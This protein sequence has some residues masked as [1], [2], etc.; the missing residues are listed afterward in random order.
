MRLEDGSDPETDTSRELGPPEFTH[1]FLHGLRLLLVTGGLTLVMFLGMM[2]ISIIATAIPQ[3][4][5]DFHRLEHVGWYIGVYSLCSAALQPLSGKVFTYFSTKWS[6]LSF[7]FIFEVGSCISGAAVS[8]EMLI[9]GRAIAG[10]GYSGVTNGAL[11]IIASAIAPPKRPCMFFPRDGCANRTLTVSQIG[12]ILGPILGGVFTEFVS[13]RWCFYINLP[14]GAFTAVCLVFI[15]IPDQVRK[16]PVSFELVRRLLPRFDLVGFALFAPAAVMGLLALQFGAS[17]YGWS[18]PV[19]I[20]LFCG[21]AGAAALFVAWEHRMKDDA[22]MPFDVIRRTAV[23]SCSINFSGIMSLAVV[24]GNYMPIY[25]Q[26]VRGLSPAMSGV[27]MLVSTASN[28]LF[29]LISGALMTRFRYPM[30]W[31]MASGALGAVACGL[32]STWAPGST[33][34]AVFG[35][36]VLNGARGLGMQQP[37]LVVQHVLP[38]G[39]IA[40][41]NSLMVFFSNSA[42]AVMVTIGN[43]IFQ[44]SLVAEL[45][46]R[47]PSVSPAAAIAAGGSAEAVRALAIASGADVESLLLAY[48]LSVNRVFYLLAGICVVVFV[49][50]FGIGWVDLGHKDKKDEEKV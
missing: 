29:I 48:S 18:S 40:V 36:Q 7:F 27:Y 49:S 19:V 33:L 23:W 1:E 37:I 39:K 47:A 41:G 25:F 20:G 50:A 12:M 35:Y 2:D 10:L 26:S 21:C 34:A 5:S 45:A 43:V 17:T 32:M 13:W 15:D 8:S 28:I 14:L 31:S 4:T 11:T 9:G 22:M 44:E 6:F 30:P 24:A 46:A 3:I 38:A 42:T 16:E